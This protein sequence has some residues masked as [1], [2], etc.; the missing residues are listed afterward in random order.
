MKIN[1]SKIH[2]RQGAKSEPIAGDCYLKGVKIDSLWNVCMA[3]KTE[4]GVA[5]KLD[6]HVIDLD[7]SMVRILLE[8][9]TQNQGPQA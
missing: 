4:L 1:L 8:T 7:E 3:W 9:V 6:S 5:V 2:K